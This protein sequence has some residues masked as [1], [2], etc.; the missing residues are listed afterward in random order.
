MNSI[1][2]MRSECER[3]NKYQAKGQFGCNCKLRK[4]FLL[5]S[6][7][8]TLHTKRY[9]FEQ[10]NRLLGKNYR[11]LTLSL[12]C[13]YDENWL[14]ILFTSS[15]HTC[16]ACQGVGNKFIYF[17]FVILLFGLLANITEKMS[18]LMFLWVVW[19]ISSIFFSFILQVWGVSTH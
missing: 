9:C 19:E 4:R 3:E 13:E 8:I 2:W 14:F 16:L 12:W 5:N 7:F 15:I 6:I 18:L 11:I 17:I 10:S 1:D